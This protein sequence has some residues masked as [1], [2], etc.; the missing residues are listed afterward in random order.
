MGVLHGPSLSTVFQ[1]G[2][3]RGKSAGAATKIGTTKP[4]EQLSRNSLNT[5]RPGIAAEFCFRMTSLC[6][7]CSENRRSLWSAAA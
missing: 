1:G 7:L 2:D 5:W 6:G 4:G 3:Y